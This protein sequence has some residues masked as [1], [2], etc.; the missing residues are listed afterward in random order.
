MY[1]VRDKTEIIA[2]M[3]RHRLQQISSPL[4]FCEEWILKRLK[5][6]GAARERRGKGE[7]QEA[8]FSSGIHHSS[9]NGKVKQSTK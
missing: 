8:P 5:D 3:L 6:S 4:W 9:S 1:N 2:N 7:G